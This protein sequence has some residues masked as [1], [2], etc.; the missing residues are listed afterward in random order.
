MAEHVLTLMHL[1]TLHHATRT[2]DVGDGPPQP[3]SAIDDEQ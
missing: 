3:L 2:E 1:A